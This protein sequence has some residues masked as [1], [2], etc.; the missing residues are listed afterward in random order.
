VSF[1]IARCCRMRKMS[2]KN[3]KIAKVDFQHVILLCF[4]IDLSSRL[5]RAI[6][7]H[8]KNPSNSHRCNYNKLIYPQSTTPNLH[9]YNHYS[10]HSHNTVPEQ[11]HL[12]HQHKTT[13]THHPA[14]KNSS[15]PSHRVQLP[16]GNNWCRWC[17]RC[18]LRRDYRRLRNN[19]NCINLTDRLLR[20]C[21]R[22]FE[23][24]SRCG[25]RRAWGGQS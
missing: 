8:P 7:S 4:E 19:C 21:R 10:P 16:F 2:S 17:R 18:R 13:K 5:R 22:R 23:C 12:H 11:S 25:N 24:L 20:R 14:H 6:S 15:S 9:S 3:H 1:V